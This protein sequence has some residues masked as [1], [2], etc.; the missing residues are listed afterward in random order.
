M[1]V[2]PKISE[3][4]KRTKKLVE[5]KMLNNQKIMEV[6]E[7]KIEN[8]KMKGEPKKNRRTKIIGKHNK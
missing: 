1:Q 4:K 2:E 6:V 7:P 5:Q 8:H 3:P